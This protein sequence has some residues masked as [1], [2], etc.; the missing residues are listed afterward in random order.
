MGEEESSVKLLGAWL[1]PFSCKVR[2]G[3]DLKGIEYEY[4]DEDLMNKSEALL[5]Y[6]PIFKKIPVFIHHEKPV[7]ESVVIL[8]YIE[9]MWSDDDKY[10]RLLPK[11]LHEK[12]TARFWIKFIEDKG[13]NLKAKGEIVE[14]FKTIEEHSPIGEAGNKLFFGGDKINAVDLAYVLIARWFGAMEEV[15]GVKLLEA[16]KFPKLHAWTERFKQVPVVKNNLPDY[17]A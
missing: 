2:C 17:D 6:N 9:E 3:L 12:S 13:K 14:I 11:D 10:Y 16:N 15:A 1:S 7:L 4:I 5:M 8:E